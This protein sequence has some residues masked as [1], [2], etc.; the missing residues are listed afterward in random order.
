[1]SETY[2]IKHK[3]K[4]A[5]RFQFPMGSTSLHNHAS[6]LLLVIFLVTGGLLS[7]Q[8][9]KPKSKT[10]QK[11]VL[12]SL[13]FPSGGQIYNE[14]YIKAGIV[15]GI[16]SYLIGSSINHGNK[17]ADFKRR[18]NNSL[19]PSEQ[20][21]YQQK[22]KEYRDL[23]K[24]DFWWIGI[25]TVLALTDAYVDAQLYDFESRKE[26]VKLKFSDEKLSLE[27]QF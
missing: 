19:T 5:Q 1:M 16:Q 14:K 13:V 3:D 4:T 9:E 23:Q 6:L 25:C 20:L 17:R 27:I 26:D 11:A 2:M 18:A 24:N 22:V 15:L 21:Y 7:A 10:P 12:Y 8:A